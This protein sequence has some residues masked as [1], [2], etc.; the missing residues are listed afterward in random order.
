MPAS[1]R[2]TAREEPPCDIKTKGIPVKGASPE[3]AEIFIIDC[4]I[5]NKTIP[6]PK[7]LPK[8]SGA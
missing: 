2:V 6:E 7:S 5:I 3:R 1:R 8:L 4:M